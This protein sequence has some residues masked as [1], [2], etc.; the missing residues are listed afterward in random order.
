MKVKVIRVVGR[1]RSATFGVAVVLPPWF[2]H[3]WVYQSCFHAVGIYYNNGYAPSPLH[4][5]D[6]IAPEEKK[7]EPRPAAAHPEP[8]KT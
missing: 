6:P 7:K 8:K 2:Y 5:K 4:A 1:A 3:P